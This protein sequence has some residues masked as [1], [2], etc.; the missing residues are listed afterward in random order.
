MPPRPDGTGGAEH[1]KTEEVCSLST[2]AQSPSRLSLNDAITEALS[3]RKIIYVRSGDTW[4]W[5]LEGLETTCCERG[6]SVSEIILDAEHLQSLR[7]P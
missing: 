1:T 3:T 4:L 6:V 5:T 7:T 2:L